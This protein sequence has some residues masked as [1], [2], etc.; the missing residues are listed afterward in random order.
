MPPR[1]RALISGAGTISATA[2][3]ARVLG[4]RR[5]EALLHSLLQHSWLQQR[6]RCGA[7]PPLNEAEKSHEWDAGCAGKRLHFFMI[8]PQM[9]Q[10][11]Q[12]TQLM[13][14]GQNTKA[15]TIDWPATVTPR[16][17][18][19]VSSKIRNTGSNDNACRF[20]PS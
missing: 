3:Q 18:R 7:Q 10:E 14:M 1:N 17:S 15:I 2:G 11:K 20:I 16:G 9:Q 6:C 13:H 19:C 8:R 4:C 12:A 5:G